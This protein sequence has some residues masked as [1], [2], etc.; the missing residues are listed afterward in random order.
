M[1]PLEQ[2]AYELLKQ[3]NSQATEYDPWDFG[4]P[5]LDDDHLEE[6][7]LVVIAFFK[8]QPEVLA[9]LSALKG[10]HEGCSYLAYGVCNKCGKNVNAEALE[11][12]KEFVGK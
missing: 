7:K 12:W 2:R 10:E 9:L 1:T 4:L 3:I 5:L 6:M 11:Q 8:D